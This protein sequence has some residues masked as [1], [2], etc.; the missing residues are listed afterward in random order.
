M[1]DSYES[2]LTIGFVTL[3]PVISPVE[4]IDDTVTNVGLKIVKPPP[5]M[6][7]LPANIVLFFV[8]IVVAILIAW[9]PVVRVPI[10]IVKIDGSYF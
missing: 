4:F 8:V 2:D 5:V 3:V 1:V 9:V 10:L 6:P 7:P